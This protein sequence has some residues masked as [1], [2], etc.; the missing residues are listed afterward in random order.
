[1]GA[2][3]GPTPNQRGSAEG[4]EG[5][6]RGRRRGLTNGYIVITYSVVQTTYHVSTI[7]GKKL[8][9]FF[10]GNSWPKCRILHYC[11]MFLMQSAK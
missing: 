11:H 5:R 7:R 3:A 1:M 9:A 2:K 6:R 4:Q 8:L 10:L